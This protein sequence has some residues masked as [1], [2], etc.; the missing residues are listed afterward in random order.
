MRARGK[1]SVRA[2]QK[3]AYE[4]PELRGLRRLARDVKDEV[5]SE[6]NRR[7]PTAPPIPPDT[8]DDMGD[9]DIPVRSP[10]D[11]VRDYLDRMAPTARDK[12]RKPMMP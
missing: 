10:R 12:F 3:S 4:S 7:V 11:D 1:D 8:M 9:M 6:L 5:R 2:R